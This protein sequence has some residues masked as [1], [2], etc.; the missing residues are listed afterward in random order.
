MGYIDQSTI[1]NVLT[2]EI[3]DDIKRRY[4]SVSVSVLNNYQTSQHEIFTLHSNSC[5]NFLFCTRYGNLCCFNMSICFIV[6]QKI[7]GTQ[8][9][10]NIRRIG[11]ICLEL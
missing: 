9:K 11:Y 6:P 1:P 7:Y 4:F 2:E 3:F 10:A 8:Y 5:R